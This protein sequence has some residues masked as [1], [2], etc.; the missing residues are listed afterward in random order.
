MHGRFSQIAKF[1]ILLHFWRLNFSRFVIWR[2]LLTRRRVSLISELGYLRPR[3]KPEESICQLFSLKIC[4]FWGKYLSIITPQDLRLLGKVFFME[5]N[6][7]LFIYGSEQCHLA[8]W[9]KKIL[10]SKYWKT[11]N[12]DS[13]ILKKIVLVCVVSISLPG[14][15]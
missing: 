7:F 8:I 4:D 1:C 14:K 10:I 11:D 12:I 9:E 15:V 2:L 13:K 5:R 3:L 6:H